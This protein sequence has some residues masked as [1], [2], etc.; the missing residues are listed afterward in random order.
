MVEV[1]FSNSPIF[2]PRKILSMCLLSI[3]RASRDI[4]DSLW[5]RRYCAIYFLLELSLEIQKCLH[6]SERVGASASLSLSPHPTTRTVSANRYQYL[7]VPCLDL[8]CRSVFSSSLTRVNTASP[9]APIN[10]KL[11]MHV[12]AC[13][14]CSN[15]WPTL[16]HQF[17]HRDQVSCIVLL[18]TTIDY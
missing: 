1:K 17:L 12:H 14:C 7:L 16:S 6:G 10:W 13:S 18:F 15:Y 8:S 11:H 9:L 4:K 2:P 3:L 5:Q